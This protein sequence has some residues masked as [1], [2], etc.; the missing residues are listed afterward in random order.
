MLDEGEF[1]LLDD[2]C[3]RPVRNHE[4]L[5]DLHPTDGV[6]VPVLCDVSD[7]HLFLVGLARRHNQRLF[8]QVLRLVCYYHGDR[9]AQVAGSIGIDIR[10]SSEHVESPTRFFVFV[11]FVVQRGLQISQHSHVQSRCFGQECEGLLRL[12]LPTQGNYM[13]QSAEYFVEQI[14]DQLI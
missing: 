2:R 12:V 6:F 3:H 14:F 8:E 1:V 10:V 7:Y 13:R 11:R 5:C 9:T 4:V